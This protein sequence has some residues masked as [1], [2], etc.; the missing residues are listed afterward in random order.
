MARCS[1]VC[2]SAMQG[3]MSVARIESECTAPIAELT[4]YAGF[5]GITEGL[6]PAYAR[7]ST[8]TTCAAHCLR[9]GQY[10]KCWL[11]VRQYASGSTRGTRRVVRA[12]ASTSRTVCV[13]QYSSMRWPSRRALRQVIPAC[14]TIPESVQDMPYTMPESVQHMPYQM[15]S[16]IESVQRLLYQ[17]S[18]GLVLG[19]GK[20][21][22]GKY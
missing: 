1:E 11:H 9:V 6:V 17:Y 8:T 5:S 14:T 3:G 21:R 19:V 7:V 22:G 2:R 18:I 4:R 20:R 15:P 13:G 16:T 12:R 10:N